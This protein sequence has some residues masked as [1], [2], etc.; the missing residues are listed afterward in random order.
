MEDFRLK[1]FLTAAKT[2]S[3][4]RCAEQLFISQPAVS[5]NISELEKHFRTRLFHRRGSGL[6]LTESGRL[7]EKWREKITSMYITLENEMAQMGKANQGE[8]RLRASTTIAQYVIPPVIA[9]FNGCYPDIR[10]SMITGN[11]ERIEQ[12]LFAKEI[13]LGFVENVS[14]RGCLQY[15]H[16][17]DDRLVALATS[18]AD[19]PTRIKVT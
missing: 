12:A 11:S 4:T 3:F 7:L 19:L 17:A 13:E 15:Q 6:E 5:K 14:R 2:L 16:F 8:L 9:G 1:V 18:V 10:V